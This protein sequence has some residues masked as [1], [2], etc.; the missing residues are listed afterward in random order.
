M[1]G[2]DHVDYQ[3]IPGERERLE[4]YS[5]YLDTDPMLDADTVFK[6]LAEWCQRRKREL[7]AILGLIPYPY[8]GHIEVVSEIKAQI[9]LYD[10][11]IDDLGAKPNFQASVRNAC[12]KGRDA[13]WHYYWEQKSKLIEEFTKRED[14]LRK[15]D[16]NLKEREAAIVARDAAFADKEAAAWAEAPARLARLERIG[17]AIRKAEQISKEVKT[18][19]R[20]RVLA[21][22]AQSDLIDKQ[23]ARKLRKLEELDVE[24]CRMEAVA[25]FAAEKVA[26]M[27]VECASTC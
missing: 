3:L 24:I 10:R 8:E 11:N 19:A 12:Q 14:S 2:Y 9:E 7:V 25:A 6:G 17:K 4:R 22:R 1:N 18:N 21:L 27:E 5:A 16:A 23:I 13:V 15:W 26:G 20:T